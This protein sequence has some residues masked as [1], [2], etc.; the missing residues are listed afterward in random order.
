MRRL[1]WVTIAAGLALGAYAA[2][3]VTFGDPVTALQAHA[4]QRRLR[5]DL[6]REERVSTARAPADGAALGVLRIPRIGV[7]AVVVQGTSTGDLER[8]PGHYRITGLPGSGRV[9]AVAGH[10]TTYGAWFRHLDDLTKGTPILFDYGGR[11]FTYRVTG[12]RVVVPTDWHILRYPGYEELVLSTCHPVYSASHR[13]V[14]FA[15]L[16]ATA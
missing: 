3:I 15:R 4:A 7:D 2:V 16:A 11:V 5:K 12:E 13:L 10:R 9:V 6:V 1:A 8:G 14:V